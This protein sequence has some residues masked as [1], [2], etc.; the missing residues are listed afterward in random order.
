PVPSV[1]PITTDGTPLRYEAWGEN[2]AT[3]VRCGITRKQSELSPPICAYQIAGKLK[4]KP[5]KASKMSG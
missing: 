1:P 3:Q 4:I 5:H 2:M